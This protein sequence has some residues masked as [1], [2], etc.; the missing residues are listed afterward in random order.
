MIKVKI[1]NKIDADNFLTEIKKQPNVRFENEETNFNLPSFKWIYRIILILVFYHFYQNT[2][3]FLFE[4]PTPQRAA[5][6]KNTTLEEASKKQF[7]LTKSEFEYL[8]EKA[9]VSVH[10]YKVHTIDD[11]YITVEFSYMSVIFNIII[12]IVGSFL[13]L[14]AIKNIPLL[15]IK[16]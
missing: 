13:I 8:A 3:F 15:F 16:R 6:N 2:N 10:S 1:S 7:L 5:I 12:I 11:R 14:F 9:G 4:L